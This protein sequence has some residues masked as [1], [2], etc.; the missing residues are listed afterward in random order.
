MQRTCLAFSR[1]AFDLDTWVP[2]QFAPWYSAL[3]A[4]MPSE[5]LYEACEKR[6]D[7]SVAAPIMRSIMTE[8]AHCLAVFV[9]T[10]KDETF[11]V[12]KIF[13]YL[14]CRVTVCIGRLINHYLDSVA[15]M[16]RDK[17]QNIDGLRVARVEAYI[18]LAQAYVMRRRAG[19]DSFRMGDNVTIFNANPQILIRIR[20]LLEQ[21]EWNDEER[22]GRMKLSALFVGAWAEQAGATSTS[23]PE[24]E[25]FNIKL[26]TQA[27][28]MGLRSWEDVRE[29]L[30]GF[31]YSDWMQPNGSTWFGNRMSVREAK[32]DGIKQAELLLLE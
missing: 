17:W 1:S 19:I 24:T 4:E 5:V 7:A 26:A 12:A 27:A 2:Q 10:R 22:Y 6:V 15:L 14:R 32:G 25:W 8:A 30:L 16:E 3:T 28:K 9:L 18:S 20:E 29:V 23:H 13:V 31:N 21:D 11:A